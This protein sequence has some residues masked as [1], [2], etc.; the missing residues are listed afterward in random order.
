MVMQ[1]EKKQAGREAFSTWLCVER[2]EAY[3]K[4]ELHLEGTSNLQALSSAVTQFDK[5]DSFF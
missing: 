1:K 4:A 3:L 2:R 5:L